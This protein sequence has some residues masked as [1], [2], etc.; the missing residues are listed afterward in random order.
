M[1]YLT[2]AILCLS[3]LFASAQQKF[4]R[5]LKLMGSSFT[6]T[7]VSEDAKAAASYIDTAISEI[8]RIEKLIS[9]WDQN[10]ETARINKNAVLNR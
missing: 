8:K 4:N 5:K 9:S 1:R 2:I 10:S 6:I 3:I 7:V